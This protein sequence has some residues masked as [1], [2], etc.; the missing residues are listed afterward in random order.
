MM[1]DVKYRDNIEK[2]VGLNLILRDIYKV[3]RR[4]TSIPDDEERETNV[5]MWFPSR[6]LSG[7]CRCWF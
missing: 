5:T 6:T 1:I 3:Q 2:D 7:Y 4:R